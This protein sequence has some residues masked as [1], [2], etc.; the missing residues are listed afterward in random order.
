MFD[1]TSRYHSIANARHVDVDGTSFVY[2][3]RRFLPHRA[4]LPSDREVVVAVG[5]RLDT[6]AARLLVDPLQYWRIADA[7]HAMNPFD[8]STPGRMLVVPAIGFASTSAS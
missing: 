6:I 2:K 7:S 1:P 4:P 5:D 8:L 3:K